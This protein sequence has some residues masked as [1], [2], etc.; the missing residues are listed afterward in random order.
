MRK[1]IYFKRLALDAR[2]KGSWRWFYLAYGEWQPFKRFGHGG[3]ICLH[4]GWL[5]RFW[6]FNKTGPQPECAA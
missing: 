5:K 3:W 4:L 2:H 1:K 6:N